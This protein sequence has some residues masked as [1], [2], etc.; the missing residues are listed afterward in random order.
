MSSLVN[1]IANSGS[2]AGGSARFDFQYLGPAINLDPNAGSLV[3]DATMRCAPCSTGSTPTAAPTAPNVGAELPGVNRRVSPD[4]RSPSVDEIAGGVTKRLGARALV[5]LDAV[6][7]KFEDFYSTRVDTSTGQ[8]TNELGQTF[9][10]NI[11]ENT[12]D[13]ERKYNGLNLSASWRPTDRVTLA[14]V[15]TLSRT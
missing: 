3:S 6:Y 9:D 7:R 10:I 4:L 1:G 14:G 13:V 11:V 8:V 2:N 12:N 15:Y 5:R